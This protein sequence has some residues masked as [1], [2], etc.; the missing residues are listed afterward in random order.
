V[1]R[2]EALGTGPRRVI[3]PALFGR[4]AGAWGLEPDCYTLALSAPCPSAAWAAANR[5][6]G[7]RGGLHDT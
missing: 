5:A 7:T 2:Q 1:K 6:M 4:L 3:G